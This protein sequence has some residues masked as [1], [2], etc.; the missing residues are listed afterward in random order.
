MT[1]YDRIEDYGMIGDTLSSALINRRG[2][3]D[4]LCWPRHDSE[5][6][7]LRLLDDEIGGFCDVTIDGGE[8]TSRRY[9]DGTNILETIFR[10]PSAEVALVDFMPVKARAPLLDEGPDVEA[11]NAVVRILT[12]K[13]GTVRG[14]FRTKVT[15][16]YARRR[17]VWND[18]GDRC[19][20]GQSS[21]GIA[22]DADLVLNGDSSEAEF[23]LSAGNAVFYAFDYRD[24]RQCG[25]PRTKL[26]AGTALRLLDE[27]RCYWEGWSARCTYRGPYRAQVLRSALV[28]KLL[29]HSPT[30]AIIAAPTMGLPEAIP[31]DRNYDYRYVW[32]RDASFTVTS[33][34]NLGYVREAGE[35]LRFLRTV[36]RSHGSALRLMYAIEGDVPDESEMTHLKGWRGTV[37]VCIGNAAHDQKQFDIYGEYLIA[38]HF[39]VSA[40]DRHA[41]PESY[42]LPKL[43]TN[44]ADAAMA[45]RDEPDNG[46]WEIR[47]GRAH[48]VHTKGLLFLALDRAAKMGRMMDGIARESIE[49]WEVAAQTLRDEFLRR[50]WNS[51][52]GAY[53]QAYESNVLDAAVLRA[54]ILGAIDPSDPRLQRTV[55]AI[56]SALGAGGDLVYRY[57]L[58]DGMQGQEATFLACAF[59]RVG[60]LALA[61]RRDEARAIYERLLARGNDLGLFAEQLDAAT[62]EHRGNFPQ[63]FTHM[64]IIN[65]ALRLEKDERPDGKGGAS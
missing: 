62:G 10:T 48:H 52:I 25:G 59:W 17:S 8:A 22:T 58:P 18:A 4:W 38:L 24:A 6:V 12:C 33:F 37:P 36:D 23:E 39:W 56:H 46:I 5:A 43:I 55:D 11:R 49:R 9:L 30:G 45:A 14:R 15:F 50:G 47:T 51:E 40:R 20:A 27:S 16:D 2:S 28:L 21:I 31:G 29:T 35:H 3:I 26:D 42:D 60:C 41:I 19:E 65:H 32:L 53:A 1:G 54:A 63:G 13:R 64:S 44:L 57:R 61:G 34:V 7:F